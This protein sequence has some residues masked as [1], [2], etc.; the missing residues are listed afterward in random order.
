[1][2]DSSPIKPTSED[3]P[4]RTIYECTGCGTVTRDRAAQMALY[5]RAGA[6]SCCPERNMVP[7]QPVKPAPEQDEQETFKRALLTQCVFKLNSDTMSAARWA[8][9][10][11]PAQIEQLPVVYAVHADDMPVDRDCALVSVDEVD[12]Y[13]PG[14]V[15]ALYAAPVAQTELVEALRT[16]ALGLCD[17]VENIND[18][19][20]V[21]Y[22]LQAGR[23]VNRVRDAVAALSAQGGHHDR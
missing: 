1:M 5:K 16:E 22:A 10:H 2:A 23:A 17:A 18:L 21:K 14:C 20:P 7:V 8:W 3:A 12:D 9:F 15:T 4:D 19:P 11:R 13:M 6:L